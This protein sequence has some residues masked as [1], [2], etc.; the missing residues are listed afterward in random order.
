M[1]KSIAIL[2]MLTF[3]QTA[4]AGAWGTEAF[5]N[6]DAVDWL[7]ACVKNPNGNS[8]SDAFDAALDSEL[9]DIDIGSVAIAAAEVVA[10]QQGNPGR[11]LPSD[12][13]ICSERQAK[14]VSLV[15]TA[16]KVVEKVRN[17]KH[18][19]LA[20]EWAQNNLERWQSSMDD[21]ARR[22]AVR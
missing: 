17:P 9:V 13:R 11:N 22:L 2:V 7:S 18:S 19:E 14:G 16:R 8:L 4:W 21:L 6:D 20:A 10:A 12:V 5:E 15:A 1:K 3:A